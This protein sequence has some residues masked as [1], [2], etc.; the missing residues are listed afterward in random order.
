M[1]RGRYCNTGQDVVY[2]SVCIC[3]GVVG[4]TCYACR[5]LTPMLVWNLP[6]ACGEATG[7]RRKMMT[8]GWH[9]RWG[10]DVKFRVKF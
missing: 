9:T 2:G 8:V 7:L 10:W 3:S 1:P 4:E 5:K 6:G